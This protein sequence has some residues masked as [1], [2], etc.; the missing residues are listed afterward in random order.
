LSIAWRDEDPSDRGAVGRSTIFRQVAI[1]RY[2]VEERLAFELAGAVFEPR[3]QNDRAKLKEGR[4][5]FG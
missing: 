3:D 5:Q 2:R 4:Q 1:D